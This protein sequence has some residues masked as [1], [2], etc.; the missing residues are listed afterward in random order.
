M[1]SPLRI[2]FM[3]SPAFVVPVA[4][5]VH[6]LPH[7]LIGVYCRA[8][9]AAGR[10]MKLRKV[11]VHEWAEANG[12]PVYTPTSLRTKEAQDALAA[13]KPDLCVVAGY[14]MILPQAIL[15]I[16]R[17]GC[18][19]VHPSLL[20]RWRGATPVQRSI[21]AGDAETGVCIMQLEA[22]MD[23]GPLWDV[24]RGIAITPT[25]TSGELYDTLFRLGAAQLGSV[26][27]RV[28]AG[29]KPTPQADTGVTHAA[30]IEKAD[31]QLDLTQ[32]ADVLDR[33]IR[34]FNPWPGAWFMVRG[35]QRMK[36]H[37]ARAEGTTAN[38]PGTLLDMDGLIATGNGTA[39]RLMT[40][41]REGKTAQPAAEMLRG[42]GAKVGE[43]L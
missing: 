22:G 34:A 1:S 10:N 43:I 42:F 2:V 19:N 13:L 5:A 27:S 9:E 15:D 28:V 36:V 24:Q 31:A 16:P 30:K 25:V 3:G 18:L 21:E 32:P 11:P 14:G 26:I 7:D 6:A 12:V 33:R 29:E 38:A 39:L 35:N 20:P 8:P 37:M 4:E 17:Y 23:T 40:V 41:Q